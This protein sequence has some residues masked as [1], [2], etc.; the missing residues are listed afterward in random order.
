M[1]SIVTYSD[2]LRRIDFSLVPNGPRKT[3]RLG[4]VSAK[5]AETWKARVATIVADKLSTRPH[6]AETAQWLGELDE[7][8]LARLRAV[9][10]AEGVGLSQTTLGEFL[11]RYFAAMAVKPATRTFYSHTR[12]NLEERLGKTRLLR[13]ITAADADAWRAWLIETEHLSPATVARR[14][15]A[16]RTI[17]R[18]A[19]RWKLA[20][21]NPFDGVKAGHQANE[22]RKVFVARAII[23]SVIE[24]APDA[25]WK[26]I[27]ALSR[28][29]GLRCPSEHFALKWGDIDWE[30]G[31]IRVSCPK[32]AHIAG[33]AQRIVPLF[34]ELRDRL[35]AAFAEAE[36]GAVHVVSRHRLGAMNLRRRLTQ[37]IE[38]AKV[39]QWPK[40]FHNLRASRET[41]LMREYDLATVCKW[42]GNSPA[43]AA[44]HYATSV[45]LDSD[46]KRAAGIDAKPVQQAQQNAQQSTAIDGE[47][48]LSEATS[49]REEREQT[50]EEVVCGQALASGDESD[51]WAVL[52]SN[53]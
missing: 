26:A 31:T 5:V 45:D 12:R 17:W 9:G 19:L 38:K 21:E 29:G 50:C 18:K 25:E 40:L 42:I 44:T 4:R 13:S 35:L 33:F 34:P 51:R 14:I 47:Q 53:Q 8:M 30:K 2:G 52:D 32:L 20:A 27:I 11:D 37:I 28:Y 1:A 23:E 22:A 48:R 16:A 49:N 10:L 15:I 7:S 3:L 41:E 36:P 24:A 46:F 6:D 43:I 39:V